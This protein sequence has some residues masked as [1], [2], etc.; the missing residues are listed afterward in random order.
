MTRSYRD[1]IPLRGEGCRI[2]RVLR[3]ICHNIVKRGLE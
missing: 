1:A 3:L 2:G